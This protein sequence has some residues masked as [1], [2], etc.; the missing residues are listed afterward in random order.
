M[1]KI[2]L[3]SLLVVLLLVITGCASKQYKEEKVITAKLYV[4]HDTYEKEYDIKAYSRIS[5]GWIVI[6][7]KDNKIIR[8]NE[9]NVIII[10]GE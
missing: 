7:T 4:L 5:S 8:T 9:K 2:I 1:K 6:I 3:V 10:E